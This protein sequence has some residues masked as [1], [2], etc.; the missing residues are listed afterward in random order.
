M[1][2]IEKLMENSNIY[3]QM[4]K[5]ITMMSPKV[6]PSVRPWVCF[7]RGHQFESLQV[8]IY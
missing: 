4:N 8:K 7:S 6:G 2:C 1:Y 5:A 3:E